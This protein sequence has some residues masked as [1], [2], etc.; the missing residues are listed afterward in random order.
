LF[1]YSDGECLLQADKRDLLNTK[2]LTFIHL[3]VHLSTA[4]LKKTTQTIAFFVQ[5]PTAQESKA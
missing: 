1:G 5:I 2:L 3:G 4:V